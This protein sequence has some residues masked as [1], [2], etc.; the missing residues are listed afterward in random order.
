MIPKFDST[1]FTIS[2]DVGLER[3]KVSAVAGESTV[4]IGL[5]LTGQP[6]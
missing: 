2:S 1:K 4:S 3:Q 6:S 5:W